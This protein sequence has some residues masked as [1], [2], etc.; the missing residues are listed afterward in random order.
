MPNTQCY[1]LDE[2]L[3]PVPVGVT[4]ELHIGGPGL[5]RGYLHRPG[6][7]AERFIPNPF[8][9]PNSRLYKS[10]DLARYL[11]DGAIEHRGRS[12]G[13]I[14]LRGQRIELGEIEAVGGHRRRD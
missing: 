12:D 11:P 3:N 1:I 4:G 14:K 9:P 2:A 6:L 13:Q 8:G 7:T 10:G 5:A